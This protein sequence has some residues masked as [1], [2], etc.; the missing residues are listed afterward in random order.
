MNEKQAKA[1]ELAEEN[2]DLCKVCK[3]RYDCRGTQNY[4][5]GPSFPPCADG[6]PECF[7]DYDALDEYAGEQEDCNK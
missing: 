1:Y 2:D 4:G 3:F 5:D 6:E 7:V